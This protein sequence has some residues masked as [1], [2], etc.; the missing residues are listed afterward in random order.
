M[1]PN[2]VSFLGKLGKCWFLPPEAICQPRYFLSLIFKCI[3][4]LE[5]NFKNPFP[6]GSNISFC[7]WVAYRFSIYKI[8]CPYQKIWGKDLSY[9]YYSAA[10]SAS[11]A[12]ENSNFLVTHSR[13]GWPGWHPWGLDVR[14]GFQHLEICQSRS[15]R[16]VVSQDKIWSLCFINLTPKSTYLV[17]WF[18]LL[19]RHPLLEFRRSFKT[20]LT[21]F[22]LAFCCLFFNLRCLEAIIK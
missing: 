21:I 17:I 22:L 20:R 11:I 10:W 1:L 5:S 9:C 12:F 8:C 2:R 18:Y 14:W 13:W 6:T 4:G 7:M 16:K 3:S 15:L 19:S